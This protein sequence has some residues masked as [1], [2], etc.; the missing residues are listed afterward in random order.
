VDH[1]SE[2]FPQFPSKYG[3]GGRQSRHLPNPAIK[4]IEIEETNAIYQVLVIGMKSFF[5]LLV[6]L[7]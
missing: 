3:K 4:K 1:R 2:V 7:F 6:L 5:F